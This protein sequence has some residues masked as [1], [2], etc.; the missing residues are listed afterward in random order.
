M[1]CMFCF[2]SLGRCGVYSRAVTGSVFRKL[3]L[4]GLVLSLLL[5][6]GCG[7]IGYYYQSVH[8]HLSLMQQSR[9]IKELL[10]EAAT[11]PG[12]RRRLELV[13]EVREFASIQ[14]GLPVN[15]SYHS[16][17]ALDRKAVVWNVVATPE[18]SLAPK[19]WCYPVVGCASYRGYFSQE[20]ARQYGEGLERDGLDVAV[21]P[22]AAYST[23][24]WFDDPLP[25]TVIHWPE[26]QLVGLIFHELAHQQL[27]AAGDS[28]FN[29][30]F[31]SAVEQVGVE[32]WYS[33]RDDAAGLERWRKRQERKQGFI[34]LLLQAREQLLQLYAKDRPAAG[35]RRQKS[36]GFAQ[37]RQDYLKLKEKWGG[38]DGYDHW[39]RRELN[40]AR[41]AS[42]ATYSEWVPAFLA[43]LKQSDNDLGRFYQA[44]ERL[45]DLPQPQRR[46]ALRELLSRP[47]S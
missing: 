17:A 29:E 25:S 11:D 30:A 44:C 18:F 13:L 21:E 7:T 15:D 41:L 36:A 39:F 28:A 9:P 3:L 32:R 24:G 19:Q 43:L 31:A 8:G 26:P 38:Y 33:S 47:G 27:Y 10:Q 45:A 20:Q 40:N 5:L 23:L 4:S 1:P 35:M 12:L 34:R 16:Y 37:L 46:K 22:A 2:I 6:S 14:L 42:V